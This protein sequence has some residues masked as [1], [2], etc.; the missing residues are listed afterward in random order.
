[1]S[2]REKE[3]E[4]VEDNWKTLTRGELEANNGD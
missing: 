4:R 3:R 2:E 1:M